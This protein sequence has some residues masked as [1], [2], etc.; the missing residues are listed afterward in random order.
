MPIAPALFDALNR[1]S[2]PT[3]SYDEIIGNATEAPHFNR[4][5]ITRLVPA[6]VTGRHERH[7]SA[8]HMGPAGRQVRGGDSVLPFQHLVKPGI[9]GGA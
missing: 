2:L 9:T 4:F 1:I 8:R 3:T 5:A 6:T 7:L